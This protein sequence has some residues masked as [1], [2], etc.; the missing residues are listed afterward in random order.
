MQPAWNPATELQAISR[1]HRTN[2]KKKVYVK[3]LVYSNPDMIETELVDLQNIKSVVCSKVISGEFIIPKTNK[4][5][6]FGIRIGKTLYDIVNE[7]SCD[8]SL[9]S[10]TTND[11]KSFETD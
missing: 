11:A 8:Q 2:Q 7:K 1:A 5:S 9:R 4:V 10:D 6:N 3:K